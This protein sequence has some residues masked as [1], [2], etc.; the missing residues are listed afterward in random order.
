MK[1]NKIEV[2]VSALFILLALVFVPLSS[3][4]QDEKSAAELAKVPRMT[5]EELK[6]LL[7]KRSDVVIV[8]TRDSSSYELG[9]IKGAVNIYYSPTADP[10]DREMTL[11]ALP[12]DKPIVIYCACQNEEESAPMVLELWHL[13]YDHDKITA[14][15]GGSIRWEE[16]GYPFV[17]SS[18]AAKAI[19]E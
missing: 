7:D 16:I 4:A 9:H 3:L 18:A 8:D 2:V 12:M 1:V 14:L 17:P 6:Q 10:S 11:V 15:K 13:G 19:A 5:V